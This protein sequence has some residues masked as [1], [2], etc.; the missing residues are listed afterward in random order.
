[1]PAYYLDSSALVK[2]YVTET[3]SAWVQALCQDATNAIFV[4]VRYM[5]HKSLFNAK[6]QSRKG[7]KKDHKTPSIAHRNRVL[8]ALRAPTGF[9][10][11]LRA[12][13]SLR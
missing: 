2:R 11:R 12:L 3:G 13:A 10:S 6:S 9:S 5:M 8:G 7:A 1:M 4:L